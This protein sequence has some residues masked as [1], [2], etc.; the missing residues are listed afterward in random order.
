MA[1]VTIT[2]D[3][4]Y[5]ATANVDGRALLGDVS[6]SG[7][8]LKVGGEEFKVG[9]MR[10]M[11]ETQVEQPRTPE[12]PADHPSM[13]G[14]TAEPAGGAGGTVAGVGVAT[15]ATS[16]GGGAGGVASAT[17]GAVPAADAGN[18]PSTRSR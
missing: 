9:S 13:A 10:I 2:K 1:R 6:L 18:A 17:S 14:R 7:D 16:A 4:G 3:P 15:P 5:G 8:T 11:M 12:P